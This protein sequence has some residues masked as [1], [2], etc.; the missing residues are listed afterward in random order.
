MVPNLR[1]F[2]TCAVVGN[3]GNLL[4]NS[5][6]EQIDQH[7]AV[8]RMNRGP[9]KGREKHVGSKTN[10][11][12]LNNAESRIYSNRGRHGREFEK[13]P[14]VRWLLHISGMPPFMCCADNVTIILSR[15]PPMTVHKYM[16]NMYQW[17]S[18]WKRKLVSN[19]TSVPQAKFSNKDNLTRYTILNRKTQQYA[20]K[21][22]SHFRRCLALG[23]NQTNPEEWLPFTSASSGLATI[24]GAMHLCAHVTVYGVGEDVM[25][26]TTPY[27]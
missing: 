8:F 19:L 15:V 21:A 5:F 10:F 4:H 27:Q 26:A 11:R 24:M 12:V 22:L 9:T 2:Q 7:E 14:V 6:G 18:G 13:L 17:L 25:T 16:K 1:Q 20:G 3:H 23:H